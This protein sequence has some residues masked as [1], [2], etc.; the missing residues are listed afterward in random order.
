MARLNQKG[1]FMHLLAWLDHV[2]KDIRFAARSLAKGRAFTAIALGS[3]ALG[4]GGS[5]AMY[6]V[7]YAV[8]LN[9]FVYKDLD[10]LVSIGYQSPDQR[11]A[12][13][14]YSI[15]HFVDLAQ[16]TTVFEGVIAS[17]ISDVTWTG[18]GEPQRLRGNHCTMNTFDI[19][20][21]APLIGRVSTAADAD[22]GAEPVAVLGYKF[23]QRQFGGDP[24]VLGRQFR[25]NDKVRTV[26]GVMP[27]RFMWR[28]ADVYLP[29]IFR[30]GETPEGVQA[31]HALARLKPG[32]S[33]AEAE[34]NVR[35]IL[36]EFQRRSPRDFP[37]QWRVSLPTFKEYFRSG[38]IDALWILFGAVG[39]LLVIACVNVSNL[40]LSRAAGR[41]REIAIRSSL[42]ASRSRL[43]TQLLCESILL[44]L[45]GGGLGVLV[46]YEGLR[47]IIAVV[48][49]NTIPDEAQIAMNG[50]VLLFS[51]AVSV[52]AALLF[53]VMPA[54]QMSGGDILTPLNE[55]GRGTSGGRRQRALRSALVVGE[56]AL[57][58]MLLVGASL[59]IRTLASVQGLRLG[60]RT[61]RVLSLRI[62]FS[63]Q[64]YPDASRR[65][66]FLQDVLRRIQTTPGVAAAGIDTG[67]HPLGSRGVTVEVAGNEQQDNRPVLLHETSEGYPAALSIGLADGRFFSEQEVNGRIHSAV[68]NQEFARRYLG[69]R[70]PLGRVLHIPALRRPPLALADDSFQVVGVTRDAV[71]RIFTNETLPEIFIP[72]SLAGRANQM[73]VLAQ[74]TPESI[75]RAVRAQIYAVDSGQPVTDVMSMERLLNQVV[76]SRPKFNL[77]LFAIFA[78][79]GLTLALFGVYG[80][81]ST[82]VA[83]QTREIG[84]RIALGAGFGQV[85][86]MVLRIGAK[87]LAVGVGIGL[88]GSLASVRL[89][90]ALVRNVSTF[91]PYSFAAVAALLFAAGLF[92]SFWPARRAARV[93]PV[94]AL[95]D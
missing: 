2:A 37:K 27:P 39:L 41:R 88:I 12:N 28:G 70:P 1:V 80:V 59:M 16:R 71:N 60:I 13:T 46:A 55:A 90:S 48:P 29:T 42:G 74:G 47:G 52:G 11:F 54:V 22:S 5:A 51:L 36:E 3:L 93:D 23:W 57:S 53:G 35:P 49:P 72:Y 85:I 34:A 26:I 75:D 82:A 31:V 8:I 65:V 6:S 95:R 18:N 62:P 67:L 61:D 30:R 78:A 33:I 7:I 91:D 66:A 63:D 64:R 19:M 25:L 15:D 79:L 21:V 89:L 58:V 14:Y 40:L 4:I 83:Q 20:G 87:L 17:T 69:G 92:A 24:G 38:I 73:V 86:G 50:S 44:G 10:R 81:I 43:V 76:Y 77:F 45:A 32:V 9:P 94:T 68:V 56:V 84:I